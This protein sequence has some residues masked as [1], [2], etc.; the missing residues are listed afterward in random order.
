MKN[1]DKKV[2]HSRFDFDT[3]MQS[4]MSVVKSSKVSKI[5][6]KSVKS[7]VVGV[8]KKKYIIKK[9]IHSII[10]CGNLRGDMMAFRGTTMG[11][12]TM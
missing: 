7:V 3:L 2:T 9:N 8:V 4:T 11:Q 6:K 5:N 10:C 12:L 1:K